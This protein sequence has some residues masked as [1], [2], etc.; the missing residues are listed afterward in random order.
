MKNRLI[1]VFSICMA[2]I[3]VQT[4]RGQVAGQVTSINENPAASEVSSSS[5]TGTLPD[6]DKTISMA[7]ATWD[8]G[9]F[10]A[11]VFKLLLEGLGYSVDGPKTMDNLPF[12]LAAARGEID[13]WANG[14]FPIHHNY[15][16][17]NRIKGKVEPV[18]FQVKAGAL[19]GYLVDKKSA[20]MLGITNL[21]DF[22]NPEIAEVFDRDGNGKADLIGCNPGWACGQVIDHHLD[23][24]GLR[25]TVEQIRG[26]YS[27]MIANT[28][29][30][31]KYG[32]PIF[33]YTWTPNWTTGKLVPGKDVV[34]IEVPFP[35][36][37]EGQKHLE[38]QIAIKGVP[39]CVE[40]PCAMGFPPSDIRVVANT[41]FL[42]RNPAVRRLAEVVKIPLGDIDAQNAK[43]IDGE[44]DNDD[45][46]RHARKWIHKNRGKVDQ[47]LKTAN[48]G[49]APRKRVA[50]T[51]EA[52]EAKKKEKSLR[53]ATKR[54]EPFVIYQNRRYTGFSIEL[55]KK[56]AEEMSVNYELYGVDTTAKLLDEVKRGAADLAIAGIG[57]TSKREQVLDFSH[58]FFES[59]LQIMVSKESETPLGAI[60]A[61][62]FSILLS[63]GLLYGIGLF[64]IVLFIAAHIIWLLERRHNPQF[65]KGYFNGLWQ[66]IWW[67]VVTVTTVGYGDKTPKGGMGRL[68]G[69]IWILAGYFVFAYFTASVTTTV[70]VQELRGAIDGPQDLFG[71]KVA[72]VERS[73]AAEY[74]TGQGLTTV[75]FEDIEKAYY[76][77]E[78]GEVDA[79][80]YDAP[81]LQHYALKKG[82]GRVMVVGL[83]FQEQSYGIAL[84]V[85][86]PLRE[87]INIA[88]L[89]LVEKGVYKEIHDKWFGS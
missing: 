52:V 77:L 58:P 40:D 48:A 33:F 15:I 5:E 25:D 67:A 22:K 85:D 84:Q 50:L 65:S 34:W 49:K 32:Q 73:P 51:A 81:V 63:P 87:E 57:I 16:E 86:S 62:V 23:A 43:M 59:G 2:L 61:K 88:F 41:E 10:Q 13:L 83:I 53:V 66:S 17:D 44:D 14:W 78:A 35:S 79:V 21:K 76:L 29:V 64:L 28:I 19:Q 60:F 71:K 68:F 31:G 75:K 27:P 18:G 6:E 11:E 3:L 7:R 24:Y 12:F 70:T 36:L 37:P 45:I 46:R 47:W 69:L 8:T 20:E 38:S 30:L 1:C 9:W 55:W 4:T 56:I 72:T 42:E 80:V 82:K 54:L 26:D 74:L 89:R 39:G